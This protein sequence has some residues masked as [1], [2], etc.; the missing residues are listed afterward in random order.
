MSG[1]NDS[2]D[3]YSYECTK[4]SKSK[5]IDPVAKNPREESKAEYTQAV[6]PSRL[7]NV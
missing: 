5:S 4:F 7:Y 6:H 2:D 1:L 3:F